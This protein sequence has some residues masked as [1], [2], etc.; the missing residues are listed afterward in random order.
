MWHYVYNVFAWGE[1]MV[2]DPVV[3]EAACVPNTS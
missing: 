3:T 2:T 1:S